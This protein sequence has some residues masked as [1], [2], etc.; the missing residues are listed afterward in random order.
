MAD[1]DRKPFTL[2]SDAALVLT[3]GG[4]AA[5]FFH[6]ELSRLPGL[7]FLNHGPFR[8]AGASFRDYL[9]DTRNRALARRAASLARGESELI[10]TLRAAQAAFRP[11]I[12]ALAGLVVADLSAR[13][14]TI[15]RMLAGAGLGAAAGFLVQHGARL[16][17][18]AN[19]PAASLG[20]GLAATPLAVVAGLALRQPEYE[21]AGMAVIQNGT[22]RTVPLGSQALREKL[23][24]MNATGDLVFGLNR[25]RHG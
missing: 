2:S 9:L 19:S 15:P 14:V 20:L 5:L 3:G 12:G 6:R 21:T 25:L 17:R 23:A 1:R 13:Q 7:W 18:I 10:A 16:A 24:A 11:G 4:A 22:V 8:T